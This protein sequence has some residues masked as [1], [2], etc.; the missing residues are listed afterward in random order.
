[1]AADFSLTQGDVAPSW[2][3]QLSYPDGTFPD[4]TGAT[5]WLRYRPLNSDAT[6]EVLSLAVI[7]G[8]PTNGTVRYDWAAPDTATPGVLLADWKVQLASG[9][10]ESFPPDSYLRIKIKA[11]P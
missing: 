5:V 8:T 11:K 10:V 7:V 1:M 3:R 4:L 9:K 6:A 2:T